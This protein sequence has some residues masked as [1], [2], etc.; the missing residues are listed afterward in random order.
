[1]DWAVLIVS[2]H[3]MSFQWLFADRGY[4]RKVVVGVTAGRAGGVAEAWSWCA[5][6]APVRRLAAGAGR[7]GGG[8]RRGGGVPGVVWWDSTDRAGST[9]MVAPAT[10]PPS[11]RLCQQRKKPPVLVLYCVYSGRGVGGG[12]HI[13]AVCANTALHYGVVQTEKN[14][15]RCETPVL[16]KL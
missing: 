10:P 13:D 7:G 12:G 3:G 9:A 4:K 16:V 6:Q 15:G 8:A 1:M 5:G 14:W 2:V 11:R